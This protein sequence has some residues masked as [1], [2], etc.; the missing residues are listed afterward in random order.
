MRFIWDSP[1][2]LDEDVFEDEQPTVLKETVPI[3][4]HA[5]A[6]FGDFQLVGNGSQTNQFCGKY[7]G[8][9]GCLR[10]DLHNLITLDGV[11]YKGKIDR[12]LV[13]HWCNKPSCPVCFKSGWAIREAHAIEARLKEASKR[14]GQVEHLSISLP[15][16]D[17]GL[18]LESMRRK[19]IKLL[20]V[21]GVIG[22]CLI[23]H[24]FRYN[25]R[26]QWYWSVHF[27]V[28]GFILGGYAC[29][30]NCP[31]K[32]NC[33]A[34]CDGFDARAW[35]AYQSDGYY[36]KV[37]GKRKTI[38]GT[39][40]YQLNHATIDVT[41]KRFHVATW[42]GCCSYRKLK[43]TVEMRKA[44]CRIC[45]HDLVRIRYFGDKAIVTDRSSP[46]YE[47]DSF[48]D[49]EEDG[50]IVYVESVKRRSGSYEA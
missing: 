23:F 14:F 43:V 34:S 18:D 13:H 47:R 4:K 2:V 38:F 22:S 19:I 9:K 29:C 36:V 21:R 27:H 3:L 10:V 25:L 44:G 1:S 11:S 30:R 49:Y 41:K 40:W 39:A 24:G 28:L 32:W 6:S 46:Y 17:Y 12:R 50:R 20:K 5:W 8:L 26:K 37:F 31:T 45:K 16:K 15:S 48:E 33:K 7:I 42:F 35:K